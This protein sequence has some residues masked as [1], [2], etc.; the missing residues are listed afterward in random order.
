M[1][2]D[3]N[4]LTANDPDFRHQRFARQDAAESMAGFLMPSRFRVHTACNYAN[5]VN[6]TTA[7]APSK[8]QNIQHSHFDGHHH[9]CSLPTMAAMSLFMW[10]RYYQYS[11]PGPATQDGITAWRYFKLKRLWTLPGIT[12][13]APSW[14]ASWRSQLRD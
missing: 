8:L 11:W 3:I 9:P 14:R 2:F 5:T 6:S 10:Q 1:W 13:F 4:E 7:W 12:I